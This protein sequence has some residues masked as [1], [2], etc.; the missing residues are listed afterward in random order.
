[1]HS[2]EEYLALLERDP[3]EAE[4]LC[5]EVLIHV[6]SFFRDPGAFDALETAVFPELLRRRVPGA[7]IRVWVPGCSTGEEVY[8]IAISLLGFLA[9]ANVVDAP[10][11]VFGTDVS[12]YAIERARTGKYPE[13]IRADVTPERLERLFQSK[14]G[15]VIRSTGRSATSASSLATTRRATRPSAGWT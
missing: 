11:K 9:R 3:A 14:K 6:T 1:M 15:R 8:S 2:L 13:S 5:E 10:I 7:P 12:G 4:A